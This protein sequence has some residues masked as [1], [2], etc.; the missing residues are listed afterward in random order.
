MWVEKFPALGHNPGMSQNSLRGFQHIFT[1]AAGLAVIGLPHGARA[2]DNPPT[3]APAADKTN[4]NLFNATPPDQFRPLANDAD[5][6]V[7]DPTTVDAGHVELQGSLLDYYHYSTS[8]GA[9]NYSAEQYAWS[10]RVTVGLF[11]NVD[12]FIHPSFQVASY[13]YSGAYNASRSNNGYEGINVGAKINLWGNDDG[14]TALA[15]APFVSIPNDDG[16]TVLGGADIS[17]AVRLPD[18]FY[19]KFM[20]DPFAFNNNDTDYFGIENDMS[21][22]KTFGDNLDTYAYLDTTWESSSNPWYGYAGFGVGYEIT[23]NLELFAGIGFGLTSNSY[24]Y[25]PRLGL[26]WRF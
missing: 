1:A 5:D 3:P 15:V 21:L 8:R 7:T 10:P 13:T 20:S 25:N 12:L 14:M 23:S 18:Q 11:N 26:A 24:D 9:V 4:Y 6:G 22:H 16:G 17:F 2:D 19:L